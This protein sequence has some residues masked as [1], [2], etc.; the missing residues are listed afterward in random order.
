MKIAHI[1]V[2]FKEYMLAEAKY[3]Q[4]NAKNNQTTQTFQKHQVSF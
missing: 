2:L 4:I 1:N 3:Y